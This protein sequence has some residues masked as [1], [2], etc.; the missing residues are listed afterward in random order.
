MTKNDLPIL[1]LA[2]ANYYEES[3]AY[4]RNI[5][6]E[7]EEVSTCLQ[8]AQQEGLCQ[9][10]A[11]H[12]V[13]F[14]KIIRA[15]QEY[16]QRI[17]LFHFS[18]HANAYSLLL[19]TPFRKASELL[20]D[21]F[22]H[23]LALQPQL[24]VV[25]LNGCSTRAQSQRLLAQGIP[26]VISTHQNVKDEV[27]RDMAVHFYAQLG[28]GHA[29]Q[30]AFDVSAALV[31]S[32]TKGGSPRALYRS[33][34]AA[35]RKALPWQLDYGDQVQGMA[36]W[37]LPDLSQQPLYFLPKLPAI[38]FPPCPFPGLRPYT[39]EERPIFWGRDSMIRQLYEQ[40]TD[41]GTTRLFVLY[42]SAGV[43]KTSFLEAGLLPYLETCHQIFRW[44]GEKEL[45]STF[46]SDKTDL[47][48]LLLLD[49]LSDEQ[50][51]DLPSA[52]DGCLTACPP[53]R[54]LLSVRSSQV[55]SCCWQIHHPLTTHY[56]PA[57]SW[58]EICNCIQGGRKRVLEEQYKLQLSSSL[59]HSLAH[60]LSRD[61]ASPVAPLLQ[62]AL[63]ELWTTAKEKDRSHPRFDEALYQ[64]YGGPPLWVR[65]LNTQM[66]CLPKAFQQNGLLLNVLAQSID[67]QQRDEVLDGEKLCQQFS[68]DR[69]AMSML[70][71]QLLDCYLLSDP[72]VDR[73]AAGQ[74]LRLSHLL[75]EQALVDLLTHSQKPGQEIPR[76]LR[77][78]LQND[79]L[80]Q[81]KE[82][83][84]IDRYQNSVP[85][86]STEERDLLQRSSTFL[87]A[88]Q[89]RIR[90]RRRASFS[91]VFLIL[92]WGYLF[93]HPYLLLFFLLLYL[94]H[95]GATTLRARTRAA[96]SLK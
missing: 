50:L 94:S 28:K 62:F 30:K 37:N 71:S 48:P 7:E 46:P 87:Q 26:A 89:R 36:D 5:P 78:H 15:F 65:F 10:V 74:Q 80:L 84:L 11:I 42:G 77:H 32:Q 85:L 61:Q 6:L 96:A 66:A 40:L 60:D 93:G 67:Y 73:P 63:Q 1:L 12:N 21:H 58:E 16:G 2:F 86:P 57:L 33:E 72:A 82:K 64:S 34:T 95:L 20:M 68:L 69:E 31:R 52:L 27:A 9:V 47:P 75:L 70:V 91:A 88:Q 43:G 17:V 29:L 90:R 81:E 23:F 76:I 59:V 35:L 44:D 14:D 49:N 19:E 4:L 51:T 55:D 24:K 56:L 25:F 3:K 45:P 53:L 54:I 83:R 8:G 39:A 41:P 79:S 22:V 38:E 92:S 13:T 18:G